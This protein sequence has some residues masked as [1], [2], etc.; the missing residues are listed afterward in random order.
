MT[1]P[2]ADAGG[3]GVPAPPRPGVLRP[4][5]ALRPADLSEC[6]RPA[7]VGVQCVDCVREGQTVVRAPRTQFGGRSP[8]AGRW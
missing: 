7:A 6:Q 3:T 4:L 2:M 1:E 8:T 5:P